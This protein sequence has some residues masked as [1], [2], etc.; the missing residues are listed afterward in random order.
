MIWH[1]FIASIEHVALDVLFF[2]YSIIIADLFYCILYPGSESP[3]FGRGPGFCVP[4]DALKDIEAIMMKAE[5]PDR[6]NEISA[7]YEVPQFPI[8]Q[9]EDKLKLQRQLSARWLLHCFYGYDRYFPNFNLTIPLDIQIK[10]HAH[11]YLESHTEIKQIHID[12]YANWE[13]L[14]LDIGI[15]CLEIGCILL[16]HTVKWASG[17]SKIVVQVLVE[18]T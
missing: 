17:A 18:N 14:L 2:I 1:S 15:S 11:I 7:P 3:D 6:P 8:E 12:L 9:I 5:D 10:H 4:Q 13:F 16:F